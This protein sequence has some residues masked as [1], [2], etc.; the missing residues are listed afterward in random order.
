[1]R[2]AGMFYDWDLWPD[3]IIGHRIYLDLL[4]ESKDMVIEL[5]VSIESFNKSIKD[6]IFHLQEFSKIYKASDD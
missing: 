2:I 4:Q 3:M 1:M 5:S 6:V